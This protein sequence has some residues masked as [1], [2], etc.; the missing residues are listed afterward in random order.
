MK[1]RLHRG[2]VWSFRHLGAPGFAASVLA[3]ALA[4][5]TPEVRD[6]ATTTSSTGAGGDMGCAP[7]EER[8]CYT[9]PPGTEDIGACKMG[10]QVCLPNGS[11]FGG[12][13]GEV[14]PQAENCLTPDDEACNGNDPA[15]CP[16][17]DHVWSKGFTSATEIFVKSVAV[18]PK[19]QDIVLTGDLRRTLDFGGGPLASTGS[20]DIM[21]A[22]FGP[23]GTHQW[24]KRFGDA[25]SQSGNGVV[26]DASGAIYLAGT[27]SGAIDLGNGPIMA[28]GDSDALLAKFDPE[29][30][31]MW[32]KLFGDAEMQRATSIA[33]TSAGQVVVGGS[34]NGAIDLGGGALMATMDTDG[35]VARF[36]ASGFHSKSL[37]FGGTGFEEVVGVA[38][39][40]KGNILLTG[41]FDGTIDFGVA[42]TFTSAGDDDVFHAKL[43]PSGSP[44]WARRWGDAASQDALDIAVTPSDEVVVSGRLVGAIE[45][46]DGTKI[47]A[48]PM[49]T[50]TYLAK[51]T[52]DGAP[53][54]S[55]LLGGAMSSS[56]WHLSIGVAN[57]S[58]VAAGWFSDRVDFGGGP[59]VAK[60]EPSP[61]IAKL[62]L[63]GKHLVSRTYDTAM[64]A[65]VL[66]IGV[67]PT[68]D[69]ILTGLSLSP[70]DLGGGP[71][72]PTGEMEAV[73]FL[74][75]LLP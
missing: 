17:L 43:T 57:G 18:D 25:S 29:G 45:L 13:G 27:V 52:V 26:I 15:D 46:D 35:W 63:D 49:A 10:V 68:G 62:D 40:S 67:M 34:Y 6:F 22:K 39:D 41:T 28:A 16:P 30:N 21:L 70:I 32:A 58:V 14:L 50:N 56:D 71:L 66:A 75:R 20:A 2:V 65:G 12:C 9:G 33:L 42:G 4:A 74:A 64:P 38:V 1:R 5:C 19:T 44:I 53:A 8:S 37:R 69:P 61:F 72:Q 48:P 7:D 59:L 36:D 60:T 11:G 24:S 31:L 47:E 55:K 73:L 3:M 51:L 23:D 54:W